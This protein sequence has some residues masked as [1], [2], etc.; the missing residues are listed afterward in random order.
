MDNTLKKKFDFCIAYVAFVQYVSR[1]CDKRIRIFHLDG[2]GKFVSSRLSSHFLTTGIVHQIFCP[3]THEQTGMV[4]RR[5][6][7]IREL[8]ITMLFHSHVCLC[9]LRH[10]QRLFISIIACRLLLFV[11][12]R[13]ILNCMA[14]ILIMHLFGFLVQNAFFIFWRVGTINLI[15][16]LFC[17]F[18]LGI[19]RNIKDISVFTHL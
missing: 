14:N 2:G 19:A 3:Y 12:T 18:L 10:L 5:Y 8:G 1:Q 7:I 13:L 17:V 15:L 6:P 16:S 11:L 4:K 9:W